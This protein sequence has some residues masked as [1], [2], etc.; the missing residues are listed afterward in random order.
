MTSGGIVAGLS[1]AKTGQLT[2]LGL[3][4]NPGIGKTTALVRYLSRQDASY[5][6][7]YVSPRVVINRDVTEKLAREDGAKTGILTVTTNAQII[8]AAERYH[9]ALV[10][11]GKVESRH[12]DGAVIV[13]GV[14]NLK[15]PQSS[16]LVLTPEEEHE[17]ERR[18]AGSRLAKTTLSEN[19][20]MVE[21]RSLVGVLAAMASVTRE[22]LPLNPTVNRAVLTAALQGFREKGH[23]RTTME[24]LSHLF[25]EH[26][27]GRAKT[28]ER[29]R[30]AAMQTPCFGRS[31]MPG[32][33]PSRVPRRLPTSTR[34][35]VRPVSK[36]CPRG[37]VRPIRCCASARF[38]PSPG[39]RWKPVFRWP[40]RCS[41]IR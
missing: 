23:G 40:R 39:R 13:D 28:E 32:N 41:P 20:D 18:H 33:H 22:L 8:A 7:F 37:C 26:R 35:K 4:G 38:R 16:V 1:A 34:R 12:I 21:E 24:S 3:E 29:R 2:V 10:E 6:F 17:I 27:E 9:R 14:P 19:E 31:P 11:E 25:R 30:F 5:L 36:R 15:T